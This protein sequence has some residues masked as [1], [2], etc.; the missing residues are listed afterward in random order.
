MILSCSELFII[1]DWLTCGRRF[2]SI[3]SSIATAQSRDRM[4]R[5]V[6]PPRYYVNGTRHVNRTLRV[7]VCRARSE[8]F[9]PPI[10][11]RRIPDAYLPLVH[12]AGYIGGRAERSEPVGGGLSLRNYVY[13]CADSLCRMVLE[14][15]ATEKTMGRGQGR[16]QRTNLSG[17][18]GCSPSAE[19]FRRD[20]LFIP[21]GRRGGE[22]RPPPPPARRLPPPSPAE[23]PGFFLITSIIAHGAYKISIPAATNGPS[24]EAT[25]HF[26][27]NSN[28]EMEGPQGSFEC[29]RSGGARRLE[30][31]GPLPRRMRVQ[32]ND[33]S[34]EATKHR[35]ARTVAAEQSKCTRVIKPNQTDIGRRVKMRLSHPT[36]SNMSAAAQIAERAERAEKERLE[37]AERDRAERAE[38]ER[39]ERAE[40]ERVERAERERVERAE[41][42]RAERA[43]RERV[44]RAE[45]ERVERAERERIERAERERV[46]RPDRPERPERAVPRGAPPPHQRPP[47][48]ADVSR[49]SINE[50]LI[51]LLALKPFKKP[52]LYTR[53]NSEGI[54][55]KD[56]AEVN[57][58]LPKIGSLKD[59]CYHLRRHIWNDVNED[60]PFYT[61]EE[62]RMLK[63]RKPQNLTPPLSS[64][65]ANS[66]SPRA[67][68]GGGGGGGGG[69]R[70]PPGGEDAPAAKK[71]RISHYRRPSP[72]SS[73]YAT[74]SSGERHASDNEDERTNV[75]KDNGYTL[76][77]NTVK[78]LCPSP[79]K[80]NGFRSSP[81][82]EQ[83]IVTEKD[84]TNTEQ[85]ENTDLTS[86]P[87]ENMTD[88]VDI[89]RQY[90]AI[91]SSS[92]RRAYKQ[93]FTEL[94]TEYRDLYGRVAQVAALFTQLEQQ[95]RRAEPT[96]PQRRTIEQRIVEEYQRVRNNTAYQRER[97]RVNYLHRKLNHIKRMVHQYDQLGTALPEKGPQSDMSDKGDSPTRHRKREKRTPAV[98]DRQLAARNLFTGEQ[99]TPLPPIRPKA[100]SPPPAATTIEHLP[101]APDYEPTPGKAP[102]VTTRIF[103]GPAYEHA[104]TSNPL[105]PRPAKTLRQHTPP[106]TEASLY[107]KRQCVGAE[108]PT[109]EKHAIEAGARAYSQ[110][111][112][113]PS[114]DSSIARSVRSTPSS[115]PD[116]RQQQRQPSYDLE[117][118]GG[119]AVWTDVTSY[120]TFAPSTDSKYRR[121]TPP[122][123]PQPSTSYAAA[124]MLASSPKTQAAPKPKPP[125]PPPSKAQEQEG[126]R[127]ARRRIH[128]PSTKQPQQSEKGK[129]DRLSRSNSNAPPPGDP[130]A[131]ERARQS[132][133]P[134][135]TQQRAI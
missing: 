26:S 42:E 13:R 123:S 131:R 84:I 28:A 72:P 100:P 46:E 47:P 129:G 25:F 33:D 86:V 78:D 61:E 118:M 35:M 4:V 116:R 92:V 41:R 102:A 67:S 27:I 32:A 50:R 117:E 20:A 93:E 88:L 7:R 89:E 96:S 82:V 2:K 10:R 94:Y 135:A 6:P 53:L 68:P 91:A 30:S 36:Y 132:R 90:P 122:R 5:P 108:M 14:E 101:S 52:E 125:T 58:I 64:D 69:K 109:P 22:S 9:A 110:P 73:G 1:V 119:E 71:K 98:V 65:S 120:A 55:E 62:K 124:A 21:D 29:V 106:E 79:V 66:L 34:Y 114:S 128:Q 81:P 51:Q 113:S 87:D 85:I 24:C 37:R 97:R 16:H 57:K 63:R 39:V 40:R 60:W 43:E 133:R 105:P 134:T 49:R 56:R 23:R 18:G 104:G 111:P 44:E 103:G 48:A 126:T 59:N 107:E 54:K 3:L 12:G 15:K 121:T 80:A 74:T 127:K 19:V 77:F 45:R 31:C 83:T 75:K 76:N 130:P 115:S 38:R 99:P 11:L 95:L 17:S 112:R 70:A 8:R